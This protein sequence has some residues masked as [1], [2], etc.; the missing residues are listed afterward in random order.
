M[1]QRTVVST[2]HPLFFGSVSQDFS[3]ANAAVSGDII[4]DTIGRLS[5]PAPGIFG[6]FALTP[7]LSKPF[8]PFFQPNNPSPFTQHQIHQ[9]NKRNP[10]TRPSI[11]HEAFQHL[12]RESPL[13][14][15]LLSIFRD[16]LRHC[17]FS[18]S[19]NVIEAVCL[20]DLLGLF[21]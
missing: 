4:I 19:A 15:S 20:D 16:S 12:P 6:F 8:K 14:G 17:P 1:S 13:G 11:N 10:S 3:H 18:I 7:V 5:S 9:L 21:Q 2:L